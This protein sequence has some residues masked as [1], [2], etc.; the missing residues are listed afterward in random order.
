[1]DS[2][3]KKTLLQI[4]THHRQNPLDIIF[5]TSIPDSVKNSL[6]VHVID[7]NLKLLSVAF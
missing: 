7:K 6:F 1:M 5:L 4:I 2:V 3:Q